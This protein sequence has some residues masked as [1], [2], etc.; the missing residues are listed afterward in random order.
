MAGDTRD[1]LAA[2]DSVRQLLGLD[3]ST[4]D[5]TVRA[6]GSQGLDRKRGQIPDGYPLGCPVATGFSVLRLL[7]R[8]RL[9]SIAHR[10]NKIHESDEAANH[11]L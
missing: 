9:T 10:S 3:C 8:N 2:R 7:G 1:V 11:A 5:S 4:R 6:K